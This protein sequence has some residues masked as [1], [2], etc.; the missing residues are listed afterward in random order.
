M[1]PFTFET[2][3]TTSA[4]VAAAASSQAP[5]HVANPTQFLA[6]GTTLIDLMALDVM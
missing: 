5:S 4:A 2:A 1:R 3:T 6:G